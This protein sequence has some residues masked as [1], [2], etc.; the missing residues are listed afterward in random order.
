[1][2]AP[3][4]AEALIAR[5]WPVRGD[6]AVV[7]YN[8]FADQVGRL[9]L[10]YDAFMEEFSHPAAARGQPA[11]HGT[12]AAQSRAADDGRDQ[13]RAVHRR[14]AGAAY[15]LH[16][17]RADAE[18][19]H[20]G[21]LPKAAAEPLP[22]DKE[23]LVLSIDVDVGMY[24]NIAIQGRTAAAEVLELAGQYCAG[25][26]S[27]RAGQA[28]G[29]CIRARRGRHVV[30][31]GS[32]AQKVGFPPSRRRRNAHRAGSAERCRLFHEHL[33]RCGSA[34]LHLALVGVLALAALRWST[35]QPPVELAI[36]G[37]FVDGPVAPG[38]CRIRGRRR[39]QAPARGCRGAAAAK[40]VVDRRRSAGRGR[41]GG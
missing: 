24:L 21:D 31:A 32:R 23:P 35:S 22:S 8:R 7:A 26:P 4:I 28:T 18:R 38:A 34:A 13:R 29:S 19:G 17:H 12:N 40:P 5:Q 37:Y 39:H 20:P 2:V 1:M 6:P 11:S 33:R 36:E 30:A 41:R 9:E 14:D 25:N 16:G 15:H 3:G 10:R 27:A